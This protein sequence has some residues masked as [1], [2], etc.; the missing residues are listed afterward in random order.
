MSSLVKVEQPHYERVA[1]YFDAEYSKRTTAQ[2]AVRMGFKAEFDRLDERNFRGGFALDVG[3][4]SGDTTLFLA[5]SGK[6]SVVEGIDISKVGVV[7]AANKVAATSTVCIPRFEVGNVLEMDRKNSY[8]LVMVNNVL[9]Y[10]RDADKQA[11]VQK[12]MDATK[13]GGINFVHFVSSLPENFLEERLSYAQKLKEQPFRRFF[14]GSDNARAIR[15]PFE[16][17]LSKFYEDAGW[18]VLSES[19][20]D[21]E[22]NFVSVQAVTLVVQKPETE[23]WPKKRD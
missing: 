17:Q 21:S 13:P 5:Q 8:S 1:K 22:R 16:S 7:E 14:E 2:N 19:K 18:K 15:L 4:G 3:C 11:F 9:E 12:I 20:Y 10:V 6:F 23:G